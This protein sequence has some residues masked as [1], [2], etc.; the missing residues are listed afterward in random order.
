MRRLLARLVVLYQRHLSPLKGFRCAYRAVHGG[1]SCSEHFRLQL[2]G[3]GI[4]T[5]LTSLPER[6]QACRG[7]LQFSV[8]GTTEQDGIEADPE[9]KRTE[10]VDEARFCI[11]AEAGNMA[12]CFLTS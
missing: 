11:A 5:A 9:N 3:A 2:M 4:F 10:G 7:A 12:C 6:A 1:P 8:V